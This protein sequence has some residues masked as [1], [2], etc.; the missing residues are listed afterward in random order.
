MAYF[1][2]VGLCTGTGCRLNV[3]LFMLVSLYRLPSS[4]IKYN[5]RYNVIMESM[6]IFMW[7]H[8]QI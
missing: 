5:L 1:T 3:L 7:V 6:P 2:V 4:N 8:K